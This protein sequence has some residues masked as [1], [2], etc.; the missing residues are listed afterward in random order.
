MIDLRC[1]IMEEYH[2]LCFWL[3]DTLTLLLGKVEVRSRGRE[4]RPKWVV[5]IKAPYDWQGSRISLVSARS[6]TR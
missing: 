2:P 1:R 3:K 4:R 5:L 6:A